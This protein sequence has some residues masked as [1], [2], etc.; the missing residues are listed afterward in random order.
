MEN[1]N[2]ELVET[3]GEGVN[4][5]VARHLMRGATNVVT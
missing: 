2:L 3:G 4:A 5:M 1:K